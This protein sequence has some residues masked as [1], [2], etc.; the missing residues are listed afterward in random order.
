ME[1]TLLELVDISKTYGP[2]EV[3]DRVSLTLRP[4]EVHALV[5][6]N[7]AGKSTLMSIAAGLVRPDR[8]KVLMA[9]RQLRGGRQAAR[10]AGVEVV[11]QELTS[12]PAR[13]VLENVFLG[14]RVASVG[15]LPRSPALERFEKLCAASGF[16]LPPSAVVRDLSI[17]DRQVLEVLRCL[18]RRPRVLIL[19]EPTS[20]LDDKRADQLLEF[21]RRLS[22]QD[23]AVALVSHHLSDVISTADTVSVLRDGRLVSTA[24]VG[25]ENEANLIRKMVGRPLS[26]MFPP[27]HPPPPDAAAVLEAHDIWRGDVVRGVSLT[28]RAGEIVGLAGLVGAGR[29]E[30]ARCLIGA[31]RCDRGWVRVAGREPSRPRSPRGAGAAGV[32]MVPEDR[33]G[34]GLVLGRSVAE[35]LALTPRARPGRLGFALPHQLETRARE[36]LVRSDIRPRQPG[37]AVRQLSGGNQQKVLLSKWLACSPKVLIADEP[38]RGVDVGAKAAIH[39]TI[40]GAAASG[41]GVLL[42]SSELDEL[43]GLAHRVVVFRKGRI[44]AEFDEVAADRE[45]V[46]AA[47][48]GSEPERASL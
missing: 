46:I 24:P 31:D 33:K 8:G 4:G 7:G 37:L 25:A 15:S 18:V 16:W 45:R 10:T 42:I 9:G 6:E 19:D 20:S 38:T 39:G 43:M 5:G 17:A 23:I 2:V 41:I 35:N 44:V 21:L 11:T 27:K 47:A 48:F 22:E 1:A 34:Q 28:V 14:M 3:L 12:V 13:S 29:S 36:W 30:F 40:A 26:R 32:V